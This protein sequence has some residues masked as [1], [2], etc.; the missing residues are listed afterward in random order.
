MPYGDVN[1][2]LDIGVL[3]YKVISLPLKSVAVAVTVPSELVSVLVHSSTDLLRYSEWKIVVVE[4][5][6]AAGSKPTKTV[7]IVTKST[8]EF[9]PRHVA[10]VQTYLRCVA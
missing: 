2:R 4:A 1:T 9:I 3:S 8:A 6:E 10:N 5:V 7:P